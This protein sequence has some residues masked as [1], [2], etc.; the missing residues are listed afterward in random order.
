MRALAEDAGRGSGVKGGERMQKI[1]DFLPRARKRLRQIIHNMN[2][3]PTIM[4]MPYICWRWNDWDAEHAAAWVLVVIMLLLGRIS[5]DLRIFIRLARA[6]FIV[7]SS[8]YA[9]RKR[10]EKAQ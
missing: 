1:R 5:E 2:E 8:R 10:A 3:N 4:I 7:E 6:W 9:E